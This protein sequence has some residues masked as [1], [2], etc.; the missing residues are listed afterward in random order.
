MGKILNLG[1]AEFRRGGKCIPECVMQESS[2]FSKVVYN[3]LIPL[4]YS[5]KV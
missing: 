5:L 1:V 4:L 3:F 2:I